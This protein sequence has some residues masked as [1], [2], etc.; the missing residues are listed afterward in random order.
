MGRKI[1]ITEKQYKTFLKEGILPNSNQ[2]FTVQ[3]NVPSGTDPKKAVTDTQNAITSTV[4]ST[5]G[6]KFKVVANDPNSPNT[7]IVSKNT[8]NTNGTTT[9]VSEGKL[10]TKKQL[11]ENRLKELKKNSEVYTVKDFIKKFDK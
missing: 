4:G 10:I 11:Q 1:R 3:A 9:P 2:E 6:K 7:Q 5:N 8:T